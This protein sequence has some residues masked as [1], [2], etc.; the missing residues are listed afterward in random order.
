MMIR[1]I[2]EMKEDM[3]KNESQENM[4]KQINEFNEKAKKQLNELK[5]I[6][7]NI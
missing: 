6:Q 3:Q 5:R 7:A 2:N 4:D 1:V